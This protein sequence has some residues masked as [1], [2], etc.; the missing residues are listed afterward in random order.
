MNCDDETILF[1]QASSANTTIRNHNSDTTRT[2][3]A[4]RTK[5]EHHERADEQTGRA[6]STVPYIAVVGSCYRLPRGVGWGGVGRFARQNFGTHFPKGPS[7]TQIDALSLDPAWSP[8]GVR[9]THNQNCSKFYPKLDMCSK[10]IYNYPKI[11]NYRKGT[12]DQKCQNLLK[13]RPLH[14]YNVRKI[15]S[16]S[17][18]LPLLAKTT[19]CLKKTSRTFFAA[20]LE[21]MVGFS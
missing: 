18:S 13:P 14:T 2:E 4:R 10:P 12:E 6:W 9:R 20:T 16:P 15:L 11:I 21:N 3:L 19:V 1:T 8:R 7:S 17:F 5:T